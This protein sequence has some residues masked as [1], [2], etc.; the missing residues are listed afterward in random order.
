MFLDQAVGWSGSAAGAWTVV[1]TDPLTVTPSVRVSVSGLSSGAAA[2]QRGSGAVPTV[3]FV[4]SGNETV[5]RPAASVVMVVVVPSG[6]TYVRAIVLPDRSAR[7]VETRPSADAT[8]TSSGA[9]GVRAYV[10]TTPSASVSDA[11]RPASSYA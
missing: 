10:V 6:A 9:L 11:S 4:P 2:P 8:R 7:Y 1:A 3:S 5:R